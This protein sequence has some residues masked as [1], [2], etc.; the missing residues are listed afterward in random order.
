[1]RSNS[2]A[3]CFA[4]A[5]ILTVP[6]S[7]RVRKSSS[8]VLRGTIR[9]ISASAGNSTSCSTRARRR[10]SVATTLSLPALKLSSTPL[11]SG[12]L[13]STEAA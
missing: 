13:A 4:V 7:A 11:S 5:R 10:L 9:S 6:V 1:M 8:T 3:I 2:K 12:R